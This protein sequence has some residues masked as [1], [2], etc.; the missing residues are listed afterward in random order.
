MLVALS[1]LIFLLLRLTPGDPIDA[2][3]DPTLPMSRQILPICAKASGS[4][5]PCRCSI[6]AGCSRR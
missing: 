1:M 4:I 2:Y 5:S 6:W 3:I